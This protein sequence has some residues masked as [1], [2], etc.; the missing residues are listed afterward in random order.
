MTQEIAAIWD[1]SPTPEQWAASNQPSD[2]LLWKDGLPRQV[3]DML[4]IG[5]LVSADVRVAGYHT[6][7]SVRL[8]VGLFKFDVYGEETVYVFTRDN[9]HDVKAVVIS[10]CPLTIDYGLIYHEVTEDEL[11]TVRAKAYAY[12]STG[13]G[14]DPVPFETD[15][16]MDGWCSDSILRSGG[17]VY[18]CGTTA[19][20]YY[21]GMERSGVP[22]TAFERY[23]HGG[24]MLAVGVDG[25]CGLMRLVDAVRES[26]LTTINDRR[27]KAS[28]LAY[29]TELSAMSERRPYQEERLVETTAKLSA[30]GIGPFAEATH[31]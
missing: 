21:E 10:S 6:S 31:G 23:E 11:A 12:Q 9:F 15:A 24:R 28:T 22:E 27:D 2:T 16:W 7:K 8:P 17:K 13:R 18:R 20:C 29:W 30:W 5:H 4:A 26:V 14:F 3:K 1:A 19:S 25:A